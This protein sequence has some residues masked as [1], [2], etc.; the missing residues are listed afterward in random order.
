MNAIQEYLY[1]QIFD[2]V[3]VGLFLL[4][5]NYC[6]CAWNKWMVSNT[7]ISVEDAVNRSLKSL[8]PNCFLPRFD[9]ALDAVLHSGHP[10]ILSALLNKYL[11]PIPLTN[12]AHSD[13]NM[14]QQ[15][16]S[17]LP[18]Y[19]HKKNMALVVIQDVSDRTH[20]QNTLITMA[21]RFEDSSLLDSLT[22]LYN[23][24]FLWRFLKGELQDA[25]REGYNVICCLFDLDY[26]KKINDELGHEAGD[27]VLCSFTAMVTSIVRPTD[28]FIRY[29]GEEFIGI[30][31]RTTIQDSINWAERIRKKLEM[32]HI[33]GSVNKKIT[34]SVGIA[35]WEP[36]DPVISAESLVKQADIKLY[37]A[38]EMGRNCIVSDKAHP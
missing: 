22:G 26:F 23:R 4:D 6:I 5:D 7:H 12:N 32:T 25:H 15:N 19:Y 21:T 33:H 2:A 30:L 8:Y 35:Y 29:G 38:K 17:I 16:V 34:C 9:W 3:P 18:L 1:E 14:M 31:T 36:E 11:I 24:R 27:E 13:L 10:Q 37:K 20:L 28:C